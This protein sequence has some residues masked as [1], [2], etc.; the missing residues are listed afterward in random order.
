MMGAPMSPD[1]PIHDLPVPMTPAVFHIL[2]ALA[3]G[4]LHGYG[5]MQAI[6]T[7]T[8]GTMRLGPG[9]L[10]R[11]IKAMLASGLIAESDERPDPALDD[12][13]RRYYRL[14]EAGWPAMASEAQRLSRLVAVAGAKTALRL[15][16]GTAPAQGEA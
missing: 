8:D 9:T 10:Y 12:E 16:T 1:Q 3:D 14:T 7:F 5:I 6:A 11:S 15:P 2:L 4:E 13:R